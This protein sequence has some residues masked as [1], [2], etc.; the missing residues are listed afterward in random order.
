VTGSLI[1]LLVAAAVAGEA[2]ARDVATGMHPLTYTVPVSKAE[3]LGG[4]FLAALALNALI[5]LAV[6]AGILLAV[7]SP[8]VDAEIVG[9]FRPAAYLT[10]YGFIALPNAL[11][12]TAI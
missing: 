6:Q 7:Y 10:A 3:Y 4:R 1:W 8:G 9:P 11:V 5:L 12:A 2:A